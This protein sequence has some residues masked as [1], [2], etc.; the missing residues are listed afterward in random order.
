ME[1]STI[2]AETIIKITYGRLED[3]RG[4][5][6]VRA[7]VHM[8][9]IVVAGLEGYAVDLIPALQYLP[10]WLPGMEFKRTAAGWRKDIDELEF[11]LLESVKDSLRSD[12]PEVRSSFM[13]KK[14]DELYQGQD[15]TA[16]DAQQLED[17]AMGLTRVGL[18]GGVETTRNTIE[19]FILAMSLFPNVQKKAHA[20]ID[21]VVGSGR[22]PK[23]E[24]L[25]NLP[26]MHAI[27]LETLRW[28][29]T[30]T[31][32]IPHVSTKDEVY[33]GYFIPKGTTVIANAWSI[34]QNP[35]YYSNPS[36]FNPERHLK[37]PPELDPRQ[38]SFGYGRRACPGKDLAFHQIWMMAT[39]ILW[40]FELVTGED[41]V[42]AWRE[43][44][45]RFTFGLLK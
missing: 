27:V 23:L 36:E 9:D 19:T 28:S 5:D 6:Y 1:I 44:V 10:S 33:N 41:D 30:T 37:Q 42:Q 2:V 40:G 25:P 38:Y 43:R 45:D 3:G 15:E 12:D 35:M 26:Y 4:M 8:M 16:R 14:F 29:P 32:G 7:N 13:F 17:E 39:A 24:D 31:F 11:S 21:K 20:E 18:L 22:P 34:A